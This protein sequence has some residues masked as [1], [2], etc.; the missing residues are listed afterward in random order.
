MVMVAL[1]L[2]GQTGLSTAGNLATQRIPGTLQSELQVSVGAAA[3]INLLDSTAGRHYIVQTVSWGRE[4]TRELG[5]G[6]LRGRFVWA[7]EVTPVFAQTSPG[8]LYGF[9]ATP[10]LWRWNFAPRPRWSAFAELSM[11]G[12]W[13]TREIPEGTSRAN[14]TAHW[15]GGARLR[16]SP[17]QSAVIA[18]RL[19]H[20]SNGNLLDGNPGVNAHVVMIGWSIVR[21]YRS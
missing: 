4:L 18:Y 10:V 17:T 13:T 1:F 12:L 21:R 14:F 2:A 7:G 16:A 6:A 8:R 9:G 3:S 19:Q 15:G 20:I 11:G 5:P